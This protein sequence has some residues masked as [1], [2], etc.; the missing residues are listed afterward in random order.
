MNG[1]SLL[2]YEDTG[3]A[4]SLVHL[5]V[6][7][8]D[9]IKPQE[10]P[11]RL[12]LLDGTPVT[13]ASKMISSIIIAGREEHDVELFTADSTCPVLIGRDLLL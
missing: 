10:E 12:L 11:L 1:E 3:A 6:V 13:V 9:C 8:K 5:S 4:K 2:P 7:P